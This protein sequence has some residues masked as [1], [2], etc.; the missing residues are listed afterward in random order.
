VQAQLPKGE[1]VDWDAVAVQLAGT[2][3]LDGVAERAAWMLAGLLLRLR[4]AVIGPGGRVTEAG[5]LMGPPVVL[6]RSGDGWMG[7]SRKES[8]SL[9]PELAVVAKLEEFR[10][11]MYW[12][13]GVTPAWGWSVEARNTMGR[14]ENYP[15]DMQLWLHGKKA[16]PPGPDSSVNCWDGTMVAAYQAGVIDK[17]WIKRRY[18]RAIHAAS[19]EYR[20]Q[21]ERDPIT[22]RLTLPEFEALPTVDSFHFTRFKAQS[23]WER[24]NESLM[25]DLYTGKLHPYQEGVDVPRGNMV[26]FDGID[27]V[28]ISLGTRDLQGRLLVLSH[29]NRPGMRPF[30]PGDRGGEG[31]V[32]VTTLEELRA[33]DKVK[34]VYFADPAWASHGDLG[35]HPAPPNRL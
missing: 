18:D 10:G 21:A 12:R 1:A 32:Q 17:G 19:M 16:D 24:H 11:R 2:G 6:A 14:N 28:A 35:P 22:G 5:D 26:F 3:P 23:P 25:G 29:Y 13:G 8:R 30:K 20:R 34:T 15:N 9:P 7:T 33:I 4:I 31:Y 27:H